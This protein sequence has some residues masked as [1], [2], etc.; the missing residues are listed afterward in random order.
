MPRSV[1]KGVASGGAIEKMSL[2]NWCKSQEWVINCPKCGKEIKINEGDHFRETA[3]GATL[4]CGQEVGGETCSFNIQIPWM[5]HKIHSSDIVK[6]LMYQIPNMDMKK[7]WAWANEIKYMN[8][9]YFLGQVEE[10][11]HDNGQL[12]KI[13]GDNIRTVDNILVIGSN[14]NRELE[15][16][17]DLTFKNIVCVDL[18]KAILEYG[19]K[20][21]NAKLDLKTKKTILCSVNSVEDLPERIR[22]YSPLKIAL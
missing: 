9:T 16:L 17:Q 15:I 2:F 1:S 14:S 4:K 3:S 13:I 22:V 6:N 21:V 12:K 20:K 8:P 5:W 11:T 19:C 18:S 10:R 7:A